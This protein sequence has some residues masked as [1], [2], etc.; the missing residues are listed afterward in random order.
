MVEVRNW[1]NSETDASVPGPSRIWGAFNDFMA[2]NYDSLKADGF[3][4][5]DIERLPV[6]ELMTQMKA[7]VGLN[8]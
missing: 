2:A 6:S 3:S 8:T 5:D 1:L 4:E 7:W